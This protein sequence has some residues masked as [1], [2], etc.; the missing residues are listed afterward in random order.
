MPPFHRRLLALLS[1][2]A[3]LAAAL[4]TGSSRAQEGAVVPFDPKRAADESDEP[5]QRVDLPDLEAVVE[6]LRTRL[7]AI[8]SR[9]IDVDSVGDSGRGLS[10]ENDFLERAVTLDGRRV[11]PRHV[12]RTVAWSGSSGH[13]VDPSVEAGARVALRAGLGR[14]PSASEIDAEVAAFDRQIAAINAEIEQARGEI[15]AH[16]EQ[17][18]AFPRALES[19]W[20]DVALPDSDLDDPRAR[21]S[22]GPAIAEAL[23]ERMGGVDPQASPDPV[24]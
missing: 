1:I 15:R 10:P 2:A 14:E 22:L 21:A 11:L 3:L 23:L 12:G 19:R 13:L 24:D 4:V 18:G 16:Y 8:A 17:E 6:Y 20:L 5:Q 9:A 7:A